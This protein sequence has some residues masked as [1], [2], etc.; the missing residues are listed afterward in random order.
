MEYWNGGKLEC[1]NAL[2]S[3]FQFS[4]IPSIKAAHQN[5]GVH[6]KFGMTQVICLCLTA[7]PL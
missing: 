4:S 1:R 6:K 2:Y 5:D 3:V 7:F